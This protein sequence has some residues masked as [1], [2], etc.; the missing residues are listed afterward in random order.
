MSK[1]LRIKPISDLVVAKDRIVF[2]S[3]RKVNAVAKMIRGL[4]VD[5][6][7]DALTFCKS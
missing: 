7:V 5:K 1:R 6:A 3:T 4:R 2:A